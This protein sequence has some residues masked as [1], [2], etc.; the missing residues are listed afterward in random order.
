M[1]DEKWDEVV[2]VLVAGSGIGGLGS[3]VIAASQ[4]AD[5]AVVEKAQTVGGTTAK[6]AAYMWIPNNKYLRAS[7]RTDPRD[8][9]LRYMAKLARPQLYDPDHTTLGLPAWEFDGIA[10][11]YDHA[12]EAAEAYEELGVLEFGHAADFPDYY[13]H[14]P[15]DAAPTGRILFPAESEG[16][17]SGGEVLIRLLSE[18]CD[19]AT[20]PIRTNAR[21]SGLVQDVDG[22][23]LG[24]LV[25]HEGASRRIGVRRGV[26][27][28]T[29]GFTHAPD[30]RLRFLDQSYV[31]GCAA[32]TNTG[33][34]LAMATSAGA[35]L[36][37]MNLG[38]RAPMVLERL[39]REPARVRGSFMI[40]G[41]S[42]LIVNRFGKRV[43][44]EKV[45][46]HD[47]ARAFFH[48]DS[49]VGGYPNNPLIM[50]WDDAAARFGG[51]GFGNPI[52]VKGADDYWV[53]TA[54]SLPE[55]ERGIADRLEVLRG[56][57][58][59]TELDPDFGST[60]TATL[61]RFAEL[62]REG[63]DHDFGRGSTPIE[64]GLS[65]YFGAGDGPNPTMAPLSTEGPY[66]ATVLGPGLIDTCGG[67]QV[68]PDG[69]VLRPDG[70]P[71]P[72]LYAVGNCAA[73]AFGEAYWAGGHS[74]GFIQ[75]AAYLAGRHAAANAV[76]TVKKGEY[77]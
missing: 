44:S 69:R 37:N 43:I 19:R 50:I 48:W 24:A 2:D 65:S 57:V 3:A 36:A 39:L 56:V 9:A 34:L 55:L 47:F 77:A 33:D 23:I 75:C 25:E 52:P 63:V 11:F 51:E 59:P 38:M 35:E 18:A 14:I 8:E 22:T 61:D 46:Y 68:D 62:A 1:I 54:D 20:V 40:P 13:A 12:S 26:V 41:D 27:F 4:G 74:I 49:R 53:V 32:L 42:M 67:P 60:L 70:S 31:G 15:E 64:Q 17:P 16:A 5:V 66:H 72:G 6:S 71:I 7:G 29:G 21:L 28:A 45:P 76:N 58:G 10:A 30:L 73:A